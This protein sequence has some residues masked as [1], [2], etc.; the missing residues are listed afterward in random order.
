MGEATPAPEIMPNIEAITKYSLIFNPKALVCTHHYG[1]E[2]PPD[3]FLRVE[4][5]TKL[6]HLEGDP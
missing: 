1:S 2:S 6:T 4:K 5:R 3:E